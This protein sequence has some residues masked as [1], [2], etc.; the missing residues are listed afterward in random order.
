MPKKALNEKEK[1][2]RRT[3]Y[4]WDKFLL[5]IKVAF[6]KEKIIYKEYPHYYVIFIENKPYIYGTTVTKRSLRNQ[7]IGSKILNE[8]IKTIKEKLKYEEKM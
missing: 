5:N 7:I 3:V 2:L 4:D 1:I 6:I 8:T